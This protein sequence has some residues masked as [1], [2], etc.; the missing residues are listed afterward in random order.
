M[1]GGEL[2]KHPRKLKWFSF[3]FKL[4]LTL[5]FA[6]VQA[7]ANNTSILLKSN[8]TVWKEFCHLKNTKDY[9]L[10]MVKQLCVYIYGTLHL[11]NKTLVPIQG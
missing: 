5:N 1:S 4:L 6:L 9:N 3:F 2:E 10:D 7:Q 8:S 11:K